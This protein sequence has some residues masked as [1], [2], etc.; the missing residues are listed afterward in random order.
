VVGSA[1]LLDLP[2]TIEVREREEARNVAVTG[3]YPSFPSTP[4][5]YPME[6]DAELAGPDR[7]LA[8]LLESYQLF[9]RSTADPDSAD[10]DEAPANSLHT[11]L[12]VLD[13]LANLVDDQLMVMV[14]EIG[15]A[16]NE[17]R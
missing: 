11:M 4:S 8:D 2:M 9:T 7:A 3:P 14:S 6:A 5:P 10:A 16:A 12:A 13:G 15:R 1:L 17:R